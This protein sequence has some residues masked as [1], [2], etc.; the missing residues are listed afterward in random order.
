MQA[1]VK[2]TTDPIGSFTA[3]PSLLQARDCNST[4]DS[5]T[6]KDPRDKAN[7]TTF[8]WTAP[9]EEFG[10]FYFMLVLLYDS[11]ICVKI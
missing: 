10:D 9:S 7:G 8:T 11:K 2:D 4:S 5:V 6:H 3:I 1:R